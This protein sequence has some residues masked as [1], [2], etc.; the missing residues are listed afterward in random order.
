MMK[1]IRWLFQAMC[2]LLIT[3]FSLEEVNK[4]IEDNFQKKVKEDNEIPQIEEDF[5]EI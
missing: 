3:F 2:H 1:F 4:Y 5:E